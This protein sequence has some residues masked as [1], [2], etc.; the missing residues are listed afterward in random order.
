MNRAIG[1]LGLISLFFL[2]PTVFGGFRCK[3]DAIVNEGDTNSEVEILCGAPMNTHYQGE[4]EID[5]D[6][7]LVDRW[8]YN[9]GKGK[10]YVILDFHNGVLSKIRYGP[11]VE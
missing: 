10:F 7:V 1:I 5:A 6:K 2:P 11:R 9:P 8:T 4:V 3:P